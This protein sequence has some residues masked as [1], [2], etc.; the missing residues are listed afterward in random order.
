MALGVW[1]HGNG[2]CLSGGAR[3]SPVNQR[4]DVPCPALHLGRLGRLY[5]GRRIVAP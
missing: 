2:T 1:L 4:L 3:A 5:L